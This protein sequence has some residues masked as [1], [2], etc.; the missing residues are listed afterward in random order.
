MTKRIIPII[1]VL[2]TLITTSTFAQ[3]IA[4]K[5]N[6]LEWAIASPNIGGEFFLN[7]RISL[8]VN[9]SASP[10]KIGSFK[11]FHFSI[12]PEARYWFKRPQAGPFVGL[13]SRM[14]EYS[15]SLNDTNYKGNFITFGAT[16]GY[17]WLI[18]E[19]WNI[20][21]VIGLGYL[22]CKQKKW[23]DDEPMPEVNN[24]NIKTLA[25]IKL[26]LSFSYIIR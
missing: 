1:V 25:P 5:T 26:G 10:V 21:A 20:E 11:N 3:K 23:S 22:N 13:A 14:A 18:G 4:I 19:R 12:E 15:V 8:G 9:V 24:D 16:C 7:K 2:F 17:S 6:A